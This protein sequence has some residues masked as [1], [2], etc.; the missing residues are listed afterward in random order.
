MLSTE[1]GKES[2]S[3]HMAIDPALL[4]IS[5]SQIEIFLQVTFPFYFMIHFHYIWLAM[6]PINGVILLLYLV[7]FK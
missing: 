5:R 6:N 4:C 1:Q 3:G 7:T 2:V